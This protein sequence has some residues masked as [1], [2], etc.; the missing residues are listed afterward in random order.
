MASNKKIRLEQAQES[1]AMAQKMLARFAGGDVPAS[2]LS[3]IQDVATQ[4]TQ[5][6]AQLNQLVGLLLAEIEA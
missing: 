1:L 5:A 4:A 3:R 2:D 6:A